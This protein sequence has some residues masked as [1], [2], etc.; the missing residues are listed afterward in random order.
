MLATSCGLDECLANGDSGKWRCSHTIERGI[1]AC[2]GAFENMAF[3]TDPGTYCS[4]TN[5]PDDSVT[6]PVAVV[7]AMCVAI[8]P[9]GGPGSLVF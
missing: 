9:L 4:E 8:P 2:P 5:A 6:D 1:Y 7:A 3:C